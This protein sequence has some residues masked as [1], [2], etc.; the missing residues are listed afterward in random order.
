M[1]LLTDL[2]NINLSDTTEKIIA[3][4]IWWVSLALCFQSC[5]LFLLCL[6]MGSDFFSSSTWF[7]CEL[8]KINHSIYPTP[9]FLSTVLFIVVG[10]CRQA[11]RPLFG[12][13]W[14][15][16]PIQKYPQSSDSREFLTVSHLYADT[17]RNWRVSNGSGRYCV[18]ICALRYLSVTFF[19]SPSHKPEKAL[20]FRV[21]IWV[22]I[23][24]TR[25][26][27]CL[28]FIFVNIF[29]SRPQP[30]CCY[31]TYHAIPLQFL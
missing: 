29:I 22:Q 28:F 9:D 30:F 17:V 15:Q 26:G 23:V 8:D 20:T 14:T 18:G 5:A 25:N 27:Y 10:I 11:P 7:C 3:E 1:S 6:I 24:L 4:Y 21:L 31:F 19:V 2:I 13:H 12:F 16:I